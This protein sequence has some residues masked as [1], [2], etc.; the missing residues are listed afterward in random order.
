MTYELCVSLD[1]IMTI[2]LSIWLKIFLT[3][4]RQDPTMNFSYGSDW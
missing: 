2:Y 3:L 4:F 1:T